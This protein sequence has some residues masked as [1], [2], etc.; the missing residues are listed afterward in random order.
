VQRFNKGVEYV[1]PFGNVANELDNK[2]LA[3]A[4]T[5]IVELD[6]MGAAEY[7][8]GA[9][10]KCLAKMWDAD[11]DIQ[12]ALIHDDNDNRHIIN[13]VYP[14][15]SIKHWKD[16]PQVDIYIKEYLNDIKAIYNMTNSIGEQVKE[17][18]KNDY[19]SFNKAINGKDDKTIGWLSLDHNYAWFLDEKIALSFGKLVGVSKNYQQ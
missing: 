6:Y 17:I 10:P 7:E 5:S 11:L 8:W 14:K 13:I 9:L 1:N 16:E 2:E 19:G 15:K 4:L 18:A 12:E 3:S